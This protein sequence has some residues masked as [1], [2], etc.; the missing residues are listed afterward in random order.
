M[1]THCSIEN[2]VGSDG[3]PAPRQTPYTGR[4]VTIYGK[5]SCPYTQAA[6][7]DHAQRGVPFIYVNV[8][9]DATALARML[10]HSNGR[11][12]VPVIVDDSGQVTIGFGG[13]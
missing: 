1:A 12:A 8:K 7:D 4:M 9:K 11:R 10:V 13:T 5:D 6:R 3:D 2:I